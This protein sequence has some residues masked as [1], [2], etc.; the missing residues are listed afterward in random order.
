MSINCGSERAEGRPR[1]HSRCPNCRIALPRTLR[2]ARPIGSSSS[3]R[4]APLPEATPS[5]NSEQRREV[6]SVRWLGGLRY[7]LASPMT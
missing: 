4:A 2:S 3:E 7:L 6:K 1:S 5:G